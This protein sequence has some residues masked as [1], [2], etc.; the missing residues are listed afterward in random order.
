MR[1]Y[2]CILLQST[3]SICVCA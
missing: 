2:L 1:K 3:Q